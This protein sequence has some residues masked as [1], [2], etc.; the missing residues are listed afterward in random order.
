[1]TRGLSVGP[2]ADPAVKA[3]ETRFVATLRNRKTR[4]LSLGERVEIAETASTKP[5]N[6]REIQF[7]HNSAE[8]S[9]TSMPS[10]QVLTPTAAH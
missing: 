5:K 8:I 7:D 3:R 9:T 4:S 10:V 1:M 2:Q 6:D